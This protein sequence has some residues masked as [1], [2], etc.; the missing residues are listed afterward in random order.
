MRGDRVAV[1]GSLS[2]RDL[3]GVDRLL[4]RA[5][6]ADG[7]PPLDEQH[8]VDLDAGRH[9][10]LVPVLAR[11]DRDPAGALTGYGH[12]LRAPDGWSVEVVVDPDARDTGPPARAILEATVAEVRQ[13]GG[14]RLRYW[15]PMATTRQDGD[16]AVVGLAPERDLLQLRVPLPLPP[17]VRDAPPP[18]GV[19]LRPFRPGRDEAA[20]LAVNNRAFAGH[21]EQGGWDLAAVRER[22]AQPWFHAAGFLLAEDAGHLAG[23]CWTKIHRDADPVLGE[24]YVIAVD[25]DH[26]RRGL[27]RVLA[28]AGLD[29]L[30][31]GGVGVGMLYVDGDN[32]P[33]LALYRSLGFTVHHVDR[34]YAGE[35]PADA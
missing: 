4:D 33:A 15:A 35:I 1:G 28:V 29:H 31:A 11:R 8:R 17:E 7:H 20:W 30:A 18:P 23:F 22:E 5:A 6:D 25:P 14:G 19:A 10:R 21:P 12:L 27:G 26:H 16:A 34:A 32:E 2:A 9:E 24:I 13:R 3:A